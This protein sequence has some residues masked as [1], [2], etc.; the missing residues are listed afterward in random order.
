D[1]PEGKTGKSAEQALARY[2]P[3]REHWLHGYAANADADPLVAVEGRIKLQRDICGGGWVRAE[4]NRLPTMADGDP[5][6][7]HVLDE[8]P[9][10]CAGWGRSS[11][12]DELHTPTLRPPGVSQHLRLR[13]GA[14]P[15]YRLSIDRVFLRVEPAED[16]HLAGGS[17]G[18][19][20]NVERRAGDEAEGQ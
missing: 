20:I 2:T 4:L 11:G 18:R 9:D 5:L 10:R 16:V 17:P 8:N 6:H 14:R 12:R 13:V 3:D 19:P 15:V 7:P 1:E